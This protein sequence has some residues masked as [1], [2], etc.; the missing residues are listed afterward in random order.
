MPTPSTVNLQPPSE[1][2][3]ASLIPN[4]ENLRGAKLDNA[5]ETEI[6]KIL[7]A[8]RSSAFLGEYVFGWENKWFHDRWHEIVN[9][10]PYWIIFASVE[11]GKSW[12]LAIT[13]P[14]WEIGNNVNTTG[15]II[16]ETAGQSQERLAAIAQTIQT[17][18]LY[19]SVFPW[20]R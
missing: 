18:P 9:V 14:L 15:A 3:L 1:E 19:Q 7:E 6:A 11:H 13:R 5:L 4:V 10:E 16:S 12:Q 20:V 2:L 17:N 8:R